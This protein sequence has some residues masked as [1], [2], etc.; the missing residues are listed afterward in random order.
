MFSWVD[1]HLNARQQVRQIADQLG[2]RNP[3]DFTRVF[4]RHFGLTPREYRLSAGGEIEAAT[5][6]ESPDEDSFEPSA[7]LRANPL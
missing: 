1:V 4:P 2:Y 6:A 5:D 7:C 3:G